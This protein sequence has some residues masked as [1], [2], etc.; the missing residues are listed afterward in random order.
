MDGLLHERF[1]PTV[2]S[3]PK[4]EQYHNIKGNQEPASK[5]NMHTV[6]CVTNK[7]EAIPSLV[8]VWYCFCFSIL[9]NSDNSSDNL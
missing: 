5:N 9:Q 6:Y 7:K 2:L 4:Q 8:G 3:E 1:I